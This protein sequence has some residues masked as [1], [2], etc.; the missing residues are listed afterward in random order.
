[1]VLYFVWGWLFGGYYY[2][3]VRDCVLYE[4]LPVS[5]ILLAVAGLLGNGWPKTFRI[6]LLAVSVISLCIAI[7]APIFEEAID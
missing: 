6:F 4:A 3:W 7:L 2:R 5:S 1:M